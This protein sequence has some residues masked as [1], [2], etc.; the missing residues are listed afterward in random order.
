[1]EMDQ[2]K[3]DVDACISTCIDAYLDGSNRALGKCYGKCM[4]GGK[5]TIFHLKFNCL[6]KYY[7][8]SRKSFEFGKI[9]KFRR[10]AM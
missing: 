3:R 6:I 8:S 10:L 7:Q 1:M 2:E 4:E 9:L 5:Y